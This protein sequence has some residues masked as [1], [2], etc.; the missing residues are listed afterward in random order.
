MDIIE[1]PLM[2]DGDGLEDGWQ[3]TAADQEENADELVVCLGAGGEKGVS[4]RGDDAAE[5]VHDSGMA[6]GAGLSDEDVEVMVELEDEPLPGRAKPVLG[7]LSLAFVHLHVVIEGLEPEQLTHVP[8]RDG[9]G[10]PLVLDGGELRD[11]HTVRGA[12]P[13]RGWRQRPEGG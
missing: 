7:Y 4:V 1:S 8:G 11:A 9:V 2:R 13:V 12:R 5:L 10:D 3:S 6:D